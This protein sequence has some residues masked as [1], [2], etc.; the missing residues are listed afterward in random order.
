[1]Y[2]DGFDTTVLPAERAGAIFHD[3]NPS[4]KFHGV[5]VATTPKG[6]R[7]TSTYATPSSMR[8]SFTVFISA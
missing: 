5:M 4:G 8:T 6:L 2:G 3:A 7:T 1:M